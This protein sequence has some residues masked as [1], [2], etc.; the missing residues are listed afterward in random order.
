[1]LW[2]LRK[3][4][5]S[6][7]HNW[8]GREMQYKLSWQVPQDDATCFSSLSAA[9]TLVRRIARCYYNSQLRDDMRKRPKILHD[10]SYYNLFHRR[11]WAFCCCMSQLNI[12]TNITNFLFT[13]VVTSNFIDAGEFSTLIHHRAYSFCLL[14]CQLIVQLI[15]LEY[16][17]WK[18]MKLS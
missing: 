10:G 3:R 5:Y 14:A 15:L 18:W 11:I 9:S 6:K 17:H 2:S 8:E 16:C 7:E 1:M 4:S 13:W 12:C